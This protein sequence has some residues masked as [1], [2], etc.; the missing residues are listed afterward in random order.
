MWAKQCE[1]KLRYY[2]SNYTVAGIE[3]REPKQN[4]QIGGKFTQNVGDDKQT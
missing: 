3:H 2:M 1:R 4:P